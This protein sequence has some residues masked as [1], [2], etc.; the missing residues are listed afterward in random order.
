M[1]CSG[2]L[3]VSPSLLQS[4]SV[5]QDAAATDSWQLNRLLK[6]SLFAVRARLH[7]HALVTLVVSKITNE[8]CTL[9]NFRRAFLK[10]LPV[11]EPDQK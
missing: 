6:H 10:R 1:C 4:R 7:P 8:V 2:R 3:R 11:T 5:L 9:F